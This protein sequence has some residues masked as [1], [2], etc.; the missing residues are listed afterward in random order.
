M[1][2]IKL[3]TNHRGLTNLFIEI[4]MIQGVFSEKVN[5]KGWDSGYDSYF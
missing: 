3:K 4:I 2:R 5:G 1:Q